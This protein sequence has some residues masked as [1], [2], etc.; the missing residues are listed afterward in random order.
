MAFRTIA[1]DTRKGPKQLLSS[2]VNNHG[3]VLEMSVAAPSQRQVTFYNNTH[4]HEIELL[5]LLSIIW[6]VA[7]HKIGIV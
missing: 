1:K 7:A 2:M 3:G 6:H 5:G 4:T